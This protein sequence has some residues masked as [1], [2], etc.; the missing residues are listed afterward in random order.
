MHPYKL[1]S[2]SSDQ[3]F[4]SIKIQWPFSNRNSQTLHDTSHHEHRTACRCQCSAVECL[5]VIKKVKV[6]KKGIILTKMHSELSPLI[7]YV[8][9]LIV[10]I[11]SKFQVYMFRNG[12]EMTKCYCFARQQL[13]RQGY[14]NTSDFLQKQPS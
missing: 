11:Y 13:R 8:A 5:I 14:C 10:N 4:D 9:L 1:Y 12:R 3:Y 7:V 2:N 6:N